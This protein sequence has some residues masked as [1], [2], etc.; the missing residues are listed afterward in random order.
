ML[1]IPGSCPL[2]LLVK[3]PSVEDP[4]A[5]QFVDII[6]NYEQDIQIP[7][8]LPLGLKSEFRVPIEFLALQ[9]SQK[10]MAGVTCGDPP[11]D[12]LIE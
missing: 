8:L 9:P 3:P 1:R 4:S 12:F 7:I 5:V 6:Q 11:F 10:Q 2:S